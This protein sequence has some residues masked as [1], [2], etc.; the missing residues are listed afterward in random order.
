LRIDG[1][2]VDAAVPPGW[3]GLAFRQKIVAGDAQ[4]ARARVAA[5]LQHAP[6]DLDAVP[7]LRTP[8]RRAEH[9]ERSGAVL[10]HIQRHTAL[11]GP[12]ERRCLIVAPP[13]DAR[14]HAVECEQDAL[15]PQRCRTFADAGEAHAARAVVDLQ[16]HPRRVDARG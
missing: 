6:L 10:N 4:D 7:L 15:E 3:D 13:A 5:Q 14:R 16:I 9:A 12:Q 11:E 2:R 1:I 8:R